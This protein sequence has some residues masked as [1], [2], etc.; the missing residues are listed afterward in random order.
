[1]FLLPNLFIYLIREKSSKTTNI[2]R[3]ALMG[4]PFR[5]SQICFWLTRVTKK[6]TILVTDLFLVARPGVDFQGGHPS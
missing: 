5:N 1:M 3:F 4:C 2:L 6:S